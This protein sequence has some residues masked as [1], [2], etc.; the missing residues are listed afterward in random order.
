MKWT[1]RCELPWSRRTARLRIPDLSLHRSGTDERVSILAASETQLPG[2]LDTPKP[3]NVTLKRVMNKAL[4]VSVLSVSVLATALAPTVSAQ[5]TREFLGRWDVTVT[6]ADGKS[7]P[8]WMELTDDGGMIQGRVQPRGGAWHTI[9]D[10]RVESGK[11]IVVV[12][13]ASS[14]PAMSW[15]LTPLTQ[16]SWR[17]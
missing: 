15:E 1:R 13:E 10:A 5:G 7:Y 11:L 3:G 2:T 4:F 17:A 8:Q 14:G 9:T 6:P 16:T 12:Q